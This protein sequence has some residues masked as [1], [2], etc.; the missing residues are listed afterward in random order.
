MSG[1]EKVRFALAATT[2]L[3]LVIALATVVVDD[4]AARTT[5]AVFSDTDVVG[6]IAG[7][8]V[9]A[10]G[11]P[12][13]ECADMK[14]KN[15]ILGT[16]GDDV[17]VGTDHSDLILGLGGNDRLSAEIPT[18]GNNGK[19]CLVGGPG[20]DHLDGGNAKDVLVG[21][22]GDDTIIGQ[23]GPDKLY[24]GS[25]HDYCDGGHAPDLVDQCEAGP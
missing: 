24:G 2:G 6:N 21:G 8:D 12:P 18:P 7:A 23:N 11:D 22:T 20:N 13:P 16:S 15:V 1:L 9:W 17:I 14:F 5:Y 3:V 10:V 19:D 4:D 25:G